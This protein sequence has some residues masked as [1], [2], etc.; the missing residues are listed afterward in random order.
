MAPL[1]LL[2]K[3]GST[4]AHEASSNLVLPVDLVEGENDEGRAYRAMDWITA[5]GTEGVPDAV[6]TLVDRTF[7]FGPFHDE[8]EA[9][10][11]APLGLEPAAKRQ[12]CGST[13]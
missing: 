5:N 10:A 7:F 8:E 6:M 3:G 12:C 9:A 13:A 4:V 1:G 11:A 2:L